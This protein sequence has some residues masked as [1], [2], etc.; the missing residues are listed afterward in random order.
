MSQ[1]A[2]DA[3]SGR[4]IKVSS[5]EPHIALAELS[6]KPVN[7]F[8]EDFWNEFGNI[9]D[10][11]GREPDVRVVVLASSLPRFFSAG[12]DLKAIAS[13]EELDMEPD[14]RGLQIRDHIIS[15]QRSISA[16]ERCP[17]PV[18]AAVHGIALGLSIDIMSACDI[19]Y[20]ASD[21][22]LSVKEVDIALAA[23]IGTLARLPKITGNRSMV[24][25][26]AYTAR[27]F[28]ADEAAKMGLVSKVVQGSRDE[29]VKAAIETAK[30]I[31]SKSPVAI[32]GTKH[33]LLHAR[34]HS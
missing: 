15:F 29:V 16:V 4:F 1:S 22:L 6:H 28:S 5:P 26:L 8:S 12:I 19:R 30:I 9:I 24:H 31:A 2:L 11:V 27:N 23:D 17:Y 14:R 13:L 18:I 32:L 21:A 20:V 3:L 25:E 34:D 10:K 7:A 33:L